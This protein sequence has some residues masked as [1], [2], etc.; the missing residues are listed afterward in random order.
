MTFEELQ[1]E[2]ARTMTR[3]GHLRTDVA[4]LQ[5]ANAE[6]S[7]T[8]RRLAARNDELERELVLAQETSNDARVNALALEKALELYDQERAVCAEL[9]VE[10][11]E[12]RT[13][14]EELKKK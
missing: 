10:C 2:I 4:R 11:E 7:E 6:L 13:Q 14:I 1:K 12:L 5:K 9:D 3:N 8:N